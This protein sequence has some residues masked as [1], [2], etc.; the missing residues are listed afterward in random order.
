VERL[1]FADRETLTY[2]ATFEDPSIYTRPWTLAVELEREPSEEEF[3]EYACHEGERTA[4]HLDE[5]IL[6]MQKQAR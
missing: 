2:S 6:A 1:T 3:W 4:D 5:Y